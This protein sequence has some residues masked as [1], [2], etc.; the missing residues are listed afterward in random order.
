MVPAVPDSLIRT[1]WLARLPT[2]MQAILA[3][4]KSTELDN[5]GQLADVITDA[6]G[7]TTVP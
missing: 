4:Q 1:I 3:T 2:A 6:A 5:V 7:I